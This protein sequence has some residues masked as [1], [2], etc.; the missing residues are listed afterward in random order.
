MK[1]VH[2]SNS[3]IDGGASIAASR[4]SSSLTKNGI[5]S[6]ILVQ[7]KLGNQE[8]VTSIVENYIKN[9]EEHH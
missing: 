7:K 9:Q 5:D 3:D 6:N 2:I 8:Y 4:I 1:V